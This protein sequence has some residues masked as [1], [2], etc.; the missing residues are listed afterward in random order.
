VTECI[1]LR[2]YTSMSTGVWRSQGQ[3]AQTGNFY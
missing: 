3:S 1:A 2:P